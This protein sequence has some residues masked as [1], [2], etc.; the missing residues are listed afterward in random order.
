MT[1]DILL[2]CLLR[3]DSSVAGAESGNETESSMQ[4]QSVNDSEPIQ[5]DDDVDE[6][7]EVIAEPKRKLTSVVWNEFKRV[8]LSS[9]EIK[10]QCSYCHKKLNGKSTHG[11][12]H[13]HDHLKICVLRKIKLTSQNKIMSQSSLRFSS[14]EG[15]KVSVESYT[16]DPEVARKELAAMI[17]LHEYPV[18]I[19][20]HIGFRRFVSACQPLF[21]M[22]SENTI[23]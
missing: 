11:T 1:I 7:E 17:A 8:K 3:H 10:A 9:G 2:C 21:K 18:C 19:V 23:R 20:E 4:P 5:I 16:F 13:L 22:V 12:K 15:G 14:Q 6:I